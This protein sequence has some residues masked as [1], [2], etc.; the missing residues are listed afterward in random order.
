MIAKVIRGWRPA[1]LIAYLMGPGRHEEEHRNPRIV[2][3]FDSAPAFHQ[4]PKTGAGEF[5]FDRSGPA[6]YDHHRAPAPA[7][8][9]PEHTS[10]TPRAMVSG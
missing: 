6:S 10:R 8:T 2:A 1:G 3:S 4:P 7:P 5:D 9:V